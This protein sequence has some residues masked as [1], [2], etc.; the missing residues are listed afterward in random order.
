MS[1]EQF[2]REI[3]ATIID[4]TRKMLE[5]A[6]GSKDRK[7]SAKEN[8]KPKNDKRAVRQLIEELVS[9]K[10]AK[11][12]G[13]RSSSPGLLPPGER[14][15][16]EKIPKE[17]GKQQEG[18]SKA[19][20][21]MQNDS[22]KIDVEL[23]T[24]QMEPKIEKVV[25]KQETH[26][27]SD[28]EDDEPPL[29]LPE[30][31]SQDK[32]VKEKKDK[33]ELKSKSKDGPV[34]RELLKGNNA[35]S[36]PKNEDVT[37]LK[38]SLLT[39][40][41]DE[42]V[43]QI[44]GIKREF[45]DKNGNLPRAD[46]AGGGIT[47]NAPE[48]KEKKV[49]PTA[50]SASES[51]GGKKE[52]K[53]KDKQLAVPP[54]RKDSAQAVDESLESDESL[55]PEHRLLVQLFML[56]SNQ[57]RKFIEKQGIE[58][59]LLNAH[60]YKKH[61]VLVNKSIMPVAESLAADARRYL[62]EQNGTVAPTVL[63]ATSSKHRA[64]QS[65]QP[66]TSA[67]KPK[68]SDKGSYEDQVNF[69]LNERVKRS[70]DESDL[71]LG[72]IRNKA[73]E[74]V[75]ERLESFVGRLVDQKVGY[76]MEGMLRVNARNNMQSF[77]DDPS[78]TGN[79]YINSILLRRCA[80]D[81]D[82][83]RV[84]VFDQAPESDDK[85][86]EESTEGEEEEKAVQNNAG[87][88]VCILEKRHNRQC[89]GKFLP[90]SQGKKHYR[91]FAPRDM[92]IPPVR[93]FKQDWPNALLEIK[94]TKLKDDVDDDHNV[95]D[96]RDD[97]E[98]PKGAADIT[99]VLY[100]AEII[101]WHDEVPIG[102]ILKSI[103]K[104]GLL[105]VEN[106]SI[107]VEHNLDVTPYGEDI[108]A[109][110]PA[111]PYNIPAEE[112]AR[113]V[114][115]RGECIF[116]IDPATA[117]DLD[118]ALSCKQL[119]NG[120]YQIGVHISDVTYF[121]RESSPLDELVKLRATS[122]YMVD[123]VYHM[124][125]KQ[126]CNT[127]SLLPGED[128]LA[129]SVFWEMEPDGTVL[130]TRF[131]RSV[132]NS[133]SQL[134]YEHAQL[135][136]DNPNCE[137]DED[138]FPEILH[139]Y[140]AKSLCK[141]VNTLQS[142]AMK[143]RQ[144]RMDD[145]CL[146][147]N[148]PKLTFRLDPATGRPIDYGVY[149]IRTSNEMIEDFMLLANMS[150]ASAIHKAYPDI[151]LLRSHSAPAA[152]MMKNLVRTL[153]LHGHAL[154]YTSSKDIR[155]CMETII[156]SSVHPDATQSVLSVLLAKPMTRAQY[157]C[158]SFASTAEQFAHYALAIPMYTHFTSPIR[159]YADCLV[160][161]VLAAMLGI[162]VTPKRSPEE[163]QCLAM[164]CNDKKYNAKLAGEASSLLYYRHWLASVGEYET[165]AAVM[166]YAA[167]FIEVVLIHSGIVLKAAVKKISAVATVVYKP[168]EPVG[169][170]LLVPVD[171]SIPPLKI[172]LFTKVRVTVKVV[173]DVITVCSILPIVERK[174]SSKPSKA[175]ALEQSV[176]D[177]IADIKSA[178]IY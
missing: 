32:K 31:R 174:K 123:T 14:K 164:V 125:P 4:D 88:V 113:R 46:T 76:M 105:E 168:I 92:R 152:N 68:R 2:F 82:L 7:G 111:V 142:I 120:N 112:L 166:G 163:L 26:S 118:D 39:K 135:M 79:I 23:V 48:K 34:H 103:G 30:R 56:S 63:V 9:Q 147:I 104:C 162:D 5:N 64:D 15:S 50:R 177:L 175:Q 81:G 13:Q 124:L 29:G 108:L 137:V 140:S 6:G 1:D 172:T 94:Q 127:C 117:R 83:V 27:R 16:K 148:Q 77:V 53:R 38:F 167:H 169:S 126:L 78:R 150:V 128:K 74:I 156:A 116:T 8:N 59:G 176:T 102:T 57:R 136:L 106:E 54:A 160:H 11:E 129:F 144:R 165:D 69:L 37:N 33:K 157:Y 55:P 73:N 93:V 17:R 130:S 159:R 115:L 60:P 58:L 65:T 18:K 107:L 141:I 61:V 25:T 41:I 110:L 10:K 122:I 3:R 85:S 40:K 171:T 97:K 21:T 43:E 22:Q 86:G 12:I 95:D 119:P 24:F 35:K 153:S 91:M 49:K 151:S 70:K 67:S 114:D 170:C 178:G 98:S 84:F 36:K 138:Q 80:M 51:R 149:K 109:Q 66:A 47:N 158:S 62:A 90:A 45:G 89:V 20:E 134:S 146:K 52:S 28:S 75:Q 101:E 96:E 100:Q 131:E 44:D 154:S 72:D 155:E 133:C 87:F 71:V 42:I 173:K 139:G 121:L 143:L 145:G 19:K 132:I 99:E 161:R